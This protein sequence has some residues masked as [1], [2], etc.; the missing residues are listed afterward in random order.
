M[1]ETNVRDQVLHAMLHGNPDLDEQCAEDLVD[2]LVDSVAHTLA[3][4][5]RALVAHHGMPLDSYGEVLVQGL[6]NHIDPHVPFEEGG[7]ASRQQPGV[8]DDAA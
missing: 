5:Q 4:E 2:A 7:P 1:S 8:G 3:N 6:I